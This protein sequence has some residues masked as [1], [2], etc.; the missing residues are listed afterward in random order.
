MHAQLHPRY[1]I[2]NVKQDTGDNK[3]ICRDSTHLGQLF[4]NLHSIAVNATSGLGHAIQ[5]G[6]RLRRKDAD[7]AREEPDDGSKPHGHKSGGWRDAY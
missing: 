6:N 7:D 3:R 1:E 2:D 5:R 4:S